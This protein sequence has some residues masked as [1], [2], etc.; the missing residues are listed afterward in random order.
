MFQMLNSGAVRIEKREVTEA[1][2]KRRKK[3][4]IF[5]RFGKSDFLRIRIK[6]FQHFLKMRYQDSRLYSGVCVCVCGDSVY[7]CVDKKK[8]SLGDSGKQKAAVLGC[9]Q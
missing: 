7:L 8:T 1:A 2:S 9:F 4:I 5:F 3:K 6:S